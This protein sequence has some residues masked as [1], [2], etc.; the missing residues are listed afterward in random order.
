MMMWK[1][2]EQMPFNKPV[3]VLLLLVLISAVAVIVTK[4]QS[5][6]AFIALQQTEKKRDQLNEEWGRL[7]LEESTWAS[8]A[9]VEQEAKARLNMLVPGDDVTVVIRP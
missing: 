1:L 6:S 4:H 2:L 5:R 7:L 3:A 9:R 8:P